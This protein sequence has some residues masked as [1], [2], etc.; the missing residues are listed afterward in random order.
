[1]SLSWTRSSTRSF[2][3]L[4]PCYFQPGIEVVHGRMEYFLNSWDCCFRHSWM[5]PTGWKHLPGIS[6]ISPRSSH[7]RSNIEPRMFKCSICWYS[8]QFRVLN[9]WGDFCNMHVD[10]VQLCFTSY[11]PRGP[12]RNPSLPRGPRRN[13]SFHREPWRNPSY[14]SHVGAL[15]T[16]TVHRIIFKL[17]QRFLHGCVSQHPCFICTFSYSSIPA[18]ESWG[19]PSK[20]RGRDMPRSR[21]RH[22]C[23][24]LVWL[25]VLLPAIEQFRQET[26]LRNP[27]TVLVEE[28]VSDAEESD[29]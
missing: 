28:V 22:I 15:S 27:I 29:G 24:H 7:L 14:Q 16:Q 26:Y 8:K 2:I 13:P 11:L 25:Q 20:R 6:S 9:F 23:V 19:D 21:T 5:K 17:L 1:M 3:T 12:R 4:A 10:I 18:W